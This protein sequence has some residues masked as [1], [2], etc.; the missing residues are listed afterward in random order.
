MESVN[1]LRTS[2]RNFV[3]GAAVT[4]AAA[5]FPHLISAS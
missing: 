1:L 5:L 3:A 2:R 4:G